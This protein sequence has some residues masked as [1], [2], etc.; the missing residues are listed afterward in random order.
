M[1][2][3]GRSCLLALIVA[4]GSSA[5]AITIGQGPII[6]TDTAGNTYREEF[7][8]W[9]P[10]DLRALDPVG[11]TSGRYNFNDGYDDSRDLVAFYSHADSDPNGNYYFRVDLYD[12]KL[13]A[14]NG[15]LDIYVAIN[16]SSSSAPQTP[17]LPDWTDCQVDPSHHWELCI[18]LY[19]SVNFNIYKGD[20][21]T[22]PSS[23]FLGAYYNSEL[24]SVEF[25]IKK[26]AL[27]SAGWNGSSPLYFT[28]VTTKDGTNNGPGEICA[29]GYG[30][31]CG[32][33]SK[34]DVADAFKDKDRGFSDGV[35]NGVIASSDTAGRA[36]YASI[37]H[38]NQ[39]VNKASDITWHIYD[40]S[41][42][43]KT[44][45]VRTLDTHEIFRVPLNIHLSGSLVTAALWAAQPG[46][47]SDPSDG[48][49]F[50]ARIKRLLD[51]SQTSAPCSLIGGVEAEHIMPYFEGTVNQVS[52]A[53]F[54][55]KCQLV[56]GLSVSQMKVMH[57]PE[58]V[59]RS[60]PT[61]YSP[62]NG[63]TFNDILAG[64]YSATVLDEVTHYHWWFDSANTQWSGEGG[65]EDKPA[66]HKIHKINGV[67]CFLINDREDQAKF[68]NWDGGMML[69]TRYTL[70]DKALQ[71]DQAQITV[72]FDDWEALAGKS[73][74]PGSGLPE[75]NNNQMQYQRNIRWAANHQWIEIVNLKDVLDRAT[76]PSNPHYNPAW[77]IDHGTQS[78]LSMQTYEWLKHAC[79]G[80]YDFW[81]YNQFNGN[82]GNEQNFYALVPV[83]TGLQGDYRS[84]GLTITSDAQAN[85]VDGPKLP[86]N[87]ALGDMNT[88]GT[89]IRD[90]WDD[91]AAVPNNALKR[92]AEYMY[93]TMIFET[94][95]HEEDN[96]DYHSHNYQN[97]FTNPDTSWDGMVS[98]N[99]RLINHLRDVGFINY[100]ARWAN[101]VATLGQG[102]TTIVST[103][104]WDQDGL[105][106][107]AL[108]N[109]KVLAI[110]EARG[111]RMIYAFHYHPTAGPICII[112]APTANPSSPGEEELSGLQANR[113]SALKDMNDGTYVDAL[114]TVQ[115]NTP[116]SKSIRFIS[117]D[118]K[119]TKTVRLPD[120]T[121]RFDVTY[122]ESVAGALYVRVGASPNHLDLLTS[123]RS[124][125]FSASAPG[126][127]GVANSAGGAVFVTLD[128]GVTYN[129]TPMFAGYQNRNLALTEEIEMS[130]NG[131]FAFAI[132]ADQGELAAR[133]PLFEIY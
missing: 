23:N 19:D 67:Y 92:L 10:T 96:G 120:N 69:D 133:V 55:E 29:G 112:G 17:W 33:T 11:A 66:E 70:L 75:A 117:P 9:N 77:V 61:G 100:A 73:F 38:G 16:T 51:P 54:A 39:S 47:A 59:I 98:W 119:I 91:L 21:S 6:G 85:A 60:Y 103:G 131:T 81:Y 76:N 44:G 25:G 129:P 71:V 93:V 2:L 88:P 107:Y 36:K 128:S 65:T 37:A 113:C 7:Q 114:Y 127:Y 46:G 97:P 56:F 27:Y 130:G 101:D 72:V 78:N 74:N 50:I 83:L 35:L 40:S 52:M 45:F 121:A 124:H 58:R 122:N 26:A 20:F 42:S 32:D 64:G 63:F 89:I 8:D 3:K 87:K 84:R 82:P 22:L 53:R 4:L 34:S 99:L 109:N 123:G 104:D 14:E 79:E 13:G 116:D 12:L 43:Y 41:N 132:G 5:F 28:V 105:P 90:T 111:G 57:T 102:P 62:L 80:S 1:V 115:V 95:W 108:K 18:A 110:F 24:D 15:N 68:G 86:S 48:P 125:L 30:P 106:E 126:Y 31:G 49:S 118:G 94:A